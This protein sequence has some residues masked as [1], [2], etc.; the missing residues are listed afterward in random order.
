MA[1]N[2]T[3]QFDEDGQLLYSSAHGLA[4]A[5]TMVPDLQVSYA[6][7]ALI[8]RSLPAI[9]GRTPTPLPSRVAVYKYSIC[10]PMLPEEGQLLRVWLARGSRL[11]RY[12][13]ALYVVY[14]AQEDRGLIRLIR[15]GLRVEGYLDRNFKLTE[16]GKQ[17]LAAVLRQL[18]F[19]QPCYIGVP[20]YILPRATHDDRARDILAAG[21]QV[22]RRNVGD[23]IWRA[24]ASFLV[25]N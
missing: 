25:G 14:A 19:R 4:G 22:V 10:E 21:A 23:D 24:V 12:G 8:F 20:R 18:G 15:R 2:L 9:L 3:D 11:R 13:K 5:V 7:K 17:W 1:V 16:P 6:G